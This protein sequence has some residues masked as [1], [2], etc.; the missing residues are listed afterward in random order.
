MH[1]TVGI[2]LSNERP[3]ELERAGSPQKHCTFLGRAR[4]GA[5]FY[6]EVDDI[7]CPLARYNLG[8][9][10][11]DRGAKREL[12]HTLVGWGDA[13]SVEAGMKYLETRTRLAEGVKYILYFPIPE[14]EFDPDIVITILRPAKAMRAVRSITARTGMGVEC[15][16]SGIGAICGECTAYP[17]VTGRPVVSLGCGGSRPGVGLADPELFFAVPRSFMQ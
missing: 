12:A 1:D 10:P 14:A 13:D 15:T 16:T 6:V 17:L 5:R 4:A 2:L 3:R 9:D 7:S 8:L 11:F